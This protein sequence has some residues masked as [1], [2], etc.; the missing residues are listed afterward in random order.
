[1]TSQLVGRC[2]TRYRCSS[3][4]I[5]DAGVDAQVSSYSLD[6]TYIIITDTNSII[7]DE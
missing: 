5:T 3:E 4:R 1:M 2:V 6:L 7:N